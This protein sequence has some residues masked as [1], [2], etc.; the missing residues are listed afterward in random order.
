M[1]AAVIA[2][3][4]IAGD[5]AARV[6]A[7]RGARDAAP[8]D[9]HAGWEPAETRPDPVAVLEAQG[10]SRVP[11]LV[12]IRYG[13]MLT[14]PFAFYRGAA[15]VMAQD[16]AAVPRTGLQV[17]L[18]GDAHLMNFGAY[19]APDR[20]LVFDINDFDET[21]PGPFEWDVKRL[22]ASLEIAGRHRELK[23]KHRRRLVAAAIRQYRDAM[24]DFAAMGNLAVWYA[25]M[26]AKRLV[27]DFDDGSDGDRAAKA[28]RKAQA[29]AL[30]KDSLR[31]VAKLTERRDGGVRIV[32]EPPLIVPVAD[33]LTGNETED[34]STLL[35]NLLLSYRRS[36]S[37]ERARLLEGYRIVDMAH[38][39]VGVGSVGLRAWILLLEGRDADDPLVLQAKEAQASVLSRFAGE[40]RYAN[41]GKRVVVGQRLMQAASD[42]FLGWDR[43]TGLDGKRRDFY[44][45]QLWDGKA[46]VDLER[47]P[48]DRLAIYG[49]ACGWTLA[50]AHARSGDRIA[51]AAYLGETDAFDSAMVAFATEYAEQ[52]ERDHAA[53]ADDARE[54][55]IE[56]QTGV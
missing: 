22:A 35:H 29:K 9:A 41:Q 53:L 56:A 39:V 47:M 16:L 45:R 49:R 27:R 48:S 32:R 33:M 6:A 4:E 28:L 25:R 14:S 7:G 42:I 15:A 2:P 44:V 3:A 10:Q 18:C 52:N 37:P 5:V 19:A 12:P 23:P 36:L 50:R 46:T 1:A 11:E 26:D 17:Q 34:L 21:L 30:R 24:R 31:A 8:I 54:G 55:R 38:K 51:I 40:S 43:V 20:R 13:R